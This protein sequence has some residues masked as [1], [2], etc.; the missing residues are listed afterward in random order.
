MENPAQTL[1]G[2]KKELTQA[3]N[4]AATASKK[5]DRLAAAQKAKE[6]KDKLFK[7]LH[8]YEQ[9]AHKAQQAME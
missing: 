1:Q 7:M 9:G 3:I 8:S 4:K 6:L 2:M 5:E